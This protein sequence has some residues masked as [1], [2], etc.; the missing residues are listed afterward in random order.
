MKHIIFLV[1]I[2]SAMNVVAGPEKTVT[3]TNSSAK[4]IRITYKD[5]N[6]HVREILSAN[7]SLFL[8]SETP[9]LMVSDSEN[10]RYKLSLKRDI[11]HWIVNS[12]KNRLG[13]GLN[14]FE[15]DQYL[16]Q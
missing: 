5:Q 9:Y 6:C 10:K 7:K 1:S 16:S 11:S 12:Q 8:V 3:I 2:F 4:P 15:C 14:V 13:G